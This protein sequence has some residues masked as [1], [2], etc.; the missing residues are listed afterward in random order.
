MD[1]FLEQHNQCQVICVKHYIA[2]KTKGF[3][4]C[5]QGHVPGHPDIHVQCT[6]DCRLN[7]NFTLTL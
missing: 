5:R 4:K 7:F 6:F 2:C 1:F 3:A